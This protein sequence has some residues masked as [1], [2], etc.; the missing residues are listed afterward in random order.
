MFYKRLIAIILTRP[1]PEHYL[2]SQA[3]P[4]GRGPG[5]DR[6]DLHPKFPFHCQHERQISE[7]ASAD[8]TA[9]T[10]RTSPVGARR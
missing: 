8:A 6:A 10:K 4:S 3:Q 9:S 2:C 5:P 1:G 7:L